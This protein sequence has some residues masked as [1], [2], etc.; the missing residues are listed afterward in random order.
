M[1]LQDIMNVIQREAMKAE[2]I[3]DQKYGLLIGE[4]RYEKK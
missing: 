3:N 2:E 4:M 1:I